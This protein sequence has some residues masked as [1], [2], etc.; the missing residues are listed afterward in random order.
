MVSD[1]TIW[2][3]KYEP[4]TLEDMILNEEIRS[5][6][7]KAI[8]EVPNM[9]L[10]GSAGVGK[11]TF[12]KIFLKAN[13]LSHMWVN[14]SN[15]TGIDFMREKVDQ[16]SY[17][18]SK[19]MKL[20]VFNEA[21]AL[22][23]GKSGAQKFLKQHIEDTEKI[24][25]YFFLTNHLHDISSEIKSRCITIVFDNPPIKDIGLFC[26]KILR[27]ENIKFDVK[28]L[29]K[30]IKK[31]YPDIR[32]TIW[33][34]QENSING[35]LV[36]SRIYTSEEVFKE[37]LGLIKK[38]DLNPIRTALRSNYIEYRQ[39]YQ[40]L[41]DNVGEFD[42]AGGAIMEIGDHLESNMK[43][44]NDGTREINF[45]RMVCKMYWHKIIK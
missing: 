6:L 25:R 8:K 29:S 24:C 1:T 22:S 43:M 11:G 23:D 17:A 7:E 5:K 10:A 35:E 3:F 9:I 38:K 28:I 12:T 27:A 36:D 21:D 34:L 4:Q 33:A 15:D 32:Q 20:I 31:C 37:I 30:I 45:M 42:S 18:G 41:F 44:P 40:F 2:S 19:R 14:A 26:S 13:N 39:L 16:Y